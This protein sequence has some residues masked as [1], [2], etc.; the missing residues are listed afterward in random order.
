MFVLVETLL[1]DYLC[2]C[3]ALIPLSIGNNFHRRPEGAPVITESSEP[4]LKNP[5]SGDHSSAGYLAAF[6]LIRPHVYSLR[7]RDGIHDHTSNAIIVSVG[8]LLV[9]SRFILVG[10]DRDLG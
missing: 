10:I 2:G 1:A 7:F 5:L 9:R 4:M 8:F 6:H 3:G